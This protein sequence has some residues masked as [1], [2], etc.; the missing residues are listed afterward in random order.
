MAAAGMNLITLS[1]LLGH[2]DPMTT[3]R[4][5]VAAKQLNLPEAVKNICQA[6]MEALEQSSP[7]ETASSLPNF[8]SWYERRGLL[9]LSEGALHVPTT[10]NA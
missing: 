7:I 4:Y 6:I 5:Y 1:L 9:P 2:A 10:T 3:L 8:R